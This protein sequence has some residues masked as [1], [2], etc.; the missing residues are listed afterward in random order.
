MS[1]PEEG[2]NCRTSVQQQEESAITEPWAELSGEQGQGPAQ[3]R[4]A[5]E[6][7]TSS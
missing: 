4:A 5:L 7:K 2:R 1:L 3:Q 6:P